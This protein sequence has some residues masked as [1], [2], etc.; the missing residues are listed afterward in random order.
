MATVRCPE[1]GYVF[2]TE[3][4]LR[5]HRALYHPG[6]PTEEPPE[7]AP[8][9]AAVAPPPPPTPEQAGW[10]SDPSGQGSRYWDGSRW[11][12][13]T[14]PAEPVV[15]TRWVVLAYVGAV[16]F[17]IAGL[18]LGTY[19]V[20]KGLRGHGFAAIAISIVIGAAGLLISSSDNDSGGD[21]TQDRFDRIL[22]HSRD[23]TDRCLKAGSSAH[24]INKCIQ[25]AIR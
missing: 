15:K 12:D 20:T 7:P 22:E 6:A 1:C 23:V 21:P 5:E 18:I 10:Y 8:S 19:L 16:L 9:D 24:E 4:Q 3:S 13:T 17:P 11:V 2:R 14:I 25:D